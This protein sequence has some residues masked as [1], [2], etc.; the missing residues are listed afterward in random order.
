M[1]LQKACSGDSEAILTLLALAQPDIRRYA[2]RTCRIAD[3]INDAV[4]ESTWVLYRRVGTLR[5]IAS[6]S[7]WLFAVVRHACLQLGRSIPGSTLDVSDA[8][9]EG[10]LSH[11]PTPELRIDIANAIESLPLHYREV[12]LLR[13]VE[14]LTIAEIAAKL[15]RSHEG[16][17]AILHRAHLLLREY[18]MPHVTQKR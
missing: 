9:R 18:L 2:R 15:G 16:T 12:V 14:E 3:D 11:R 6:L 4:Q 17:K 13:D 10:E 5:S 1:L 8:E 7:G